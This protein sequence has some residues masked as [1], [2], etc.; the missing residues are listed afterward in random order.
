MTTRSSTGQRSCSSTAPSCFSWF[1]RVRNFLRIDL[2]RVVRYE[3]VSSNERIPLWKRCGLDDYKHVRYPLHVAVLAG[4]YASVR[5]MLADADVDPNA[6]DILHT[7][8]T[9]LMCAVI[10]EHIASV[11]LLLQDK[12]VDPSLTR[13]D[14]RNALG[15]AIGKEDWDVVKEISADARIASA[16]FLVAKHQGLGFRIGREFRFWCRNRE[17]EQNRHRPPADRTEIIES[18]FEMA[19]RWG[20]ENLLRCL[21]MQSDIDINTVNVSHADYRAKRTADGYSNVSCVSK[22][23]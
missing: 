9:P 14:G 7:G 23:E 21:L 18:A 5:I 8:C 2:F 15:I 20:S 11:R 4:D 6:I 22:N 13:P 19:V 3:G 1:P 16:G 17:L 12:R 10:S